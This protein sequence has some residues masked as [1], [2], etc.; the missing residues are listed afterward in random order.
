MFAQFLE[1]LGR[2]ATSTICAF[3]G[4]N[5][6]RAIETDIKDFL[7]GRDIGVGAVM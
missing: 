6:N 7:D 4:E 1:R 5:G 3:V 2:R